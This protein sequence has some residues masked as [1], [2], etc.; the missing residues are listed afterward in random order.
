[1]RGKDRRNQDI[2]IEKRWVTDF[3]EKVTSL[4]HAVLDDLD[5]LPYC[6]NLGGMMVEMADSG[7]HILR[8][9]NTS[10]KVTHAWH[11]FVPTSYANS[12][13]NTPRSGPVPVR[14]ASH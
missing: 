7:E 2:E 5:Q 12:T 3:H 14:S 13:T 11:L 10:N 6:S 9:D 1:M 8:G 4:C